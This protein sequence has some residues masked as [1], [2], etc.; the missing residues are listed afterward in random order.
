VGVEKGESHLLV[1][2]RSVLGKERKK[3]EGGPLLASCER[4]GVKRDIS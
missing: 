4:K 2:L 1:N 3:G